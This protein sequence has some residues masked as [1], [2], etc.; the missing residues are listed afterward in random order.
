MIEQLRQ[1]GIKYQEKIIFQ[2]LPE[3]CPILKAAQCTPLTVLSEFFLRDEKETQRLQ[4]DFKPIVS[5]VERAKSIFAAI[6]VQKVEV[7]F[8]MQRGVNGWSV[9]VIM[10]VVQLVLKQ[11]NTNYK[12]AIKT[13]S[14]AGRSYQF[15]IPFLEGKTPQ[16]EDND[17]S[18]PC[19]CIDGNEPEAGLNNQRRWFEARYLRAEVG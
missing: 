3:F 12:I 19:N 8:C 13:R 5:L 7:G 14:C 11:V 18:Q 1:K 9:K 15:T 10:G 4:Q 16:M 2:P 17:S 6:L